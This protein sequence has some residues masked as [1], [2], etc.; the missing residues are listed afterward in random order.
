MSFYMHFSD[1]ILIYDQDKK[2]GSAEK[3]TLTTISRI[4]HY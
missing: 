4:S 1:D 2:L 3:I